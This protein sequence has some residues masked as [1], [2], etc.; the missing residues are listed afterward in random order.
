M[1]NFLNCYG[2]IF[3]QNVLLIIENFELK[4]QNLSF[5]GKTFIF[6]INDSLNIKYTN[7]V[8]QNRFMFL[9]ENN[10]LTTLHLDRA[11]PELSLECQFKD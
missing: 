5:P 7:F 8:V 10:F 9:S 2:L 11:V 1:C 4:Q 3:R 6:Y